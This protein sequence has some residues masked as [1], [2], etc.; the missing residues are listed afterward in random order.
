MFSQPAG[1]KF[2]GK[3]ESLFQINVQPGEAYD[4]GFR[5]EHVQACRKPTAA[6]LGAIVL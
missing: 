6:G 5:L 2:S 4:N 3:R 1:M